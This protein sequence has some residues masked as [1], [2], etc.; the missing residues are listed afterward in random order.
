[1]AQQIVSQ[2]NVRC[3]N[4]LKTMPVVEESR[5][6]LLIGKVNFSVTMGFNKSLKR[7]KDFAEDAPDLEVMEAA[8]QHIAC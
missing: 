6:S 8:K 7:L 2:E 5:T 3:K 4:C 1:M